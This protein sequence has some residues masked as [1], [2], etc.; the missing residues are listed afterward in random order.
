MANGE[1]RILL[2]DDDPDVLDILG[3]FI[4]VFGFEYETA[5][6]G[7][8]AVEKMKH[9]IF[10]IVLTDMMMPNM[11]GMELLRHIHNNYPETKVMVVT[12]YDRTFTYTDV[13]N[14]GA[15]DFISK[16]FNPDELEA[17][18]NR[19]IREIE[20][21]R[22]LEHLSISDG[23]TGLYN[24]RHFD[25]KIIEETRRAHRQKHD[26]YLAL[27]DVDN[28]KELNDKFGHPA[29]DKLLSSVGSILKSCIREDVDWPFRYG[30]DEFCVI[31]S[32]VSQKQACMT[33]ERILEKFNEKKLPLTGLSI[34]L[35]KFVRSEDTKLPED[36]SALVRRADNALYKAKNTGRNR[37]V[38]DLKPSCNDE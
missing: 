35:A 2:V 15:S 23:L 18:I 38:T 1:H 24:R 5:E 19:I 33:T 16:P 32:Q 31:L 30:G 21:M 14:A 34:G 27:L 11:D 7:L 28:L 10:N 8:E 22:Q 36:I 13:I 37:I 3:D 20:L 4:A 6:D 26:L 17:K 25:N 12:G 9:G 29:G